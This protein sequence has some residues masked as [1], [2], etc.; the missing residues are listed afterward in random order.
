MSTNRAGSESG[1][2]LIIALILLLVGATVGVT[3]MQSSSMEF[4]MASNTIQSKVV[5]QAAES[6]TELALNSTGNLGESYEEGIG[7][8]YNTNLGLENFPK[9]TGSAK[10]RY[11]G[12]G[13]VPGS[14]A[15]VFEGLRFE[16]Y[17][18][19]NIGNEARAGITQGAVRVVPAN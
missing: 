6:A 12:S 18:T 2:A 7:G 4:K 16:V 15:D 17:G 13:I 19:A 9:V 11:V 8:E 5:H 14:S 1:S 3:A 10:I